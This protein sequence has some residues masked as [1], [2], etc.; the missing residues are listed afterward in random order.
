VAGSERK[1]AAIL[2]ALRGRWINVL[3]TDQFTA[4]RLVREDA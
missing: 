2:A 3:V 4:R 1:Y